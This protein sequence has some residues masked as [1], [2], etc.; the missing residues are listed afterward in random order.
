VVNLEQDIGGGLT[1]PGRGNRK[2]KINGKKGLE[3]V[4]PVEE[5]SGTRRKKGAMAGHFTQGGKKVH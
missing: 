1:D 4:V 2:K 5:S 3:R